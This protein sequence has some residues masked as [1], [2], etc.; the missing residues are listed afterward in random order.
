ME[1]ILGKRKEEFEN[2]VDKVMGVYDAAG[3]AVSVFDETEILYEK[4]FGYRDVE[5]R[6]PPDEDTIFG[7][8]SVSKSFTALSVMQLQ[9][10]GILSVDDP[11][12]K[13]IPEYEDGRVKISHLLTHSA[14][15]F[16][17]KRILVKD[18]AE[19][20]GIYDGGA[21]ELGYDD[22]LAEEGLRQVCARLNAQENRLGEPGQYMSY[23]NDGYGI[24]SEI[25]HRTGGEDSYGEYVQ[26]HILEPM[27]MRRS[28]CEFIRPAQDA[29]CTELYIRREHSRDFYDNAFVLMGGGAIKSTVRDM[30]NYVRMYLMEGKIPGSAGKRLVSRG[31]VQKMCR[32]R[33][34]YHY[35]EWYGYG[36]AEK[37]IGGMTVWGHGGSLA[38]I[39]N[40]MAW[41]PRIGIGVLVFCNTTG[42]PASRVAEQ[43]FRLAGGLPLGEEPFAPVVPWSREQMKRAAGVYRSGEG[44]EV[45]L[46][47]A[48]GKMKLK[49]GGA[50][51][52]CRMILPGILEIEEPVGHDDLILMEDDGG[53][54][55]GVRFRGR[56]L[57]REV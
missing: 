20:L 57:P 33:Q 40:F 56:I 34:E 16:P 42:A 5:K 24:L 36:L 44:V 12:K 21:R 41:E 4:Y 50:P 31:S 43:A 18:V 22:R 13:Y 47:E 10:A 6:L 2:Y 25:I 7:M 38:G 32:P 48:D 17:L 54:V 39:S 46:A 45:E 26:R 28:F 37:R 51:A 1:G 49:A 29:N 53:E 35:G 3:M 55:F 11:V 27:G 9:D 30:R 8:A 14:G 15:Y 19:Q 23:S 52:R